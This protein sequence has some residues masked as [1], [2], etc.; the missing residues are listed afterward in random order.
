MPGG[1]REVQ[2]GVR[3]LGRAVWVDGLDRAPF[4]VGAGGDEGGSSLSFV[5]GGYKSRLVDTQTQTHQARQHHSLINITHL[6]DSLTHT[7]HVLGPSRMGR[8]LEQVRARIIRGFRAHHISLW[9]CL[10]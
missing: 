3:A 8:N 9:S 4:P 5:L 7:D 6:S 2:Q 1:G 10:L